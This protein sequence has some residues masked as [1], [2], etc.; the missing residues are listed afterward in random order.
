MTKRAIC[1]ITTKSHW[2]KSLALAESIHQIDASIVFCLLTV[3][4][5]KE[6]LNEVKY[7]KG[8]INM[9]V[10]NDILFN[11]TAK[12][13][14]QKYQSKTDYLRWSLKSILLLHLLQ[15]ENY[16]RLFYC[17]NDIYFC[18]DFSFL[19]EDLAHHTV[20]LTPHYYCFDAEKKQIWLEANF[21]CGLYNA[22]FIGVNKN[23]INV[24]LWWAKC[25]LYRCERKYTHGLFVDQKFLDLFPI[26]EPKTKIVRHKGCNVAYWNVL[27]NERQLVDN[28][29][30]IEKSILLFLYILLPIPFKESSIKKT[31]YC[32]II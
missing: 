24:L 17:D 3:D 12:K 10:L 15:N 9:Y 26:I 22:G 18:N 13:I 14:A 21:R 28:Q 4:A 7:T 20:L 16:E 2:Y 31:L 6:E 19:M 8:K 32:K 1:S 11:K 30:V 5:S 27:Q 29:V 25:C 23:A